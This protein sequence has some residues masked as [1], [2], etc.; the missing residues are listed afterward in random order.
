MTVLGA[1]AGDVAD[2]HNA[3]AMRR[4]AS[5]AMGALLGEALG[6]AEFHE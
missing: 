6:A 4:S 3:W 5:Q 2:A 1:A